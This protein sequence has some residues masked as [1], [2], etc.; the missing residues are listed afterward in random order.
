MRYLT[1]EPYPG[2]ALEVT[3]WRLEYQALAERGVEFLPVTEIV[4]SVPGGLVVRRGYNRA[5]ETLP[6]VDAL[7][8][9]DPPVPNVAV[10]D[11]LAGSAATIL[12]VGDAY[13][14]RGIEQATLDARLT[15]SRL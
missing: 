13:A 6:A 15:A 10:R 1:P 9:I 12:T 3:N 7:V 8:W 14:P 2:S 5:T 4:G 11:A